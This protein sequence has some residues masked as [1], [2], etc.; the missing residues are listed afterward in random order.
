MKIHPNLTDGTVHIVLTAREAVRVAEKLYRA[1]MQS[2][3]AVKAGE[4]QESTDEDV[5]EQ[6]Q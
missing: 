4:R 2:G 1:A 5:K 3:G 6:E